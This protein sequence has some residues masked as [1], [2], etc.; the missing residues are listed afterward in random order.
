MLKLKDILR[1]VVLNATMRVLQDDYDLTGVKVVVC[2]VI[3]RKSRL[4]NRA[5]VVR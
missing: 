2:Y 1:K 3:V 5:E 4:C